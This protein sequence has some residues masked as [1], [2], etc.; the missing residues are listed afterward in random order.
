MGFFSKI[1]KPFQKVANKVIKPFQKVSDKLIPN[2]LRPLLP[3]ASMFLPASGIMGQLGGLGGFGKMYAANMLTQAMGDPEADFEDLNQL[4]GILSGAQG[5]LSG[6]YADGTTSGSRL[7]DSTTLGKMDNT[8]QGVMASMQNTPM[9]ANSIPEFANRS[10]L[11]KAA[12]LGKNVAASGSDYFVDNINTLQNLGSGA[13]TLNL[14]NLKEGAKALGPS[15]AQA[16]GDVAVNYQR[17]AMRA[18]EEQE[19]ADSAEIEATSTADRG[20][21]AG[22]QMTFM[23]Q[24]GHD[25]ETIEDTLEINDLGDLYSPPVETA[26]YGGLMGRNN[27]EFGGIT[28]AL[29]NAGSR[30][31]MTENRAMGGMMNGYNMG[32]RVEL[33]QGGM[34]AKMGILGEPQATFNSPQGLGQPLGSGNNNMPVFP[35]LDKLTKGVSQAESSLENVNNR[36]GQAPAVQTGNFAGYEMGGLERLSRQQPLG[37]LQQYSP[38]Q[39]SEITGYNMG[40]SVLPQGMEMDYRGGGFIP[41]GSAER[42]DDVDA[43]VSKNEFV[44]TADAVRAAGGGSVNEGARRMYNLMNNLEAKA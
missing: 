12:D 42:A 25:E 11:T 14:E 26:A 29:K 8:P 44:M 39:Q 19:A 36:L 5:A 34:L 30:G 17:P 31:L 32:G 15:F 1:T 16:S 20:K 28:E 27:Y 37:L 33:N 18:Y 38:M 22:L 40:G 35:R 2:E 10:F 43:R 23:R 4:S 24:A 9:G 21:R 3:Y 6:Q 7:R 41:M 13:S